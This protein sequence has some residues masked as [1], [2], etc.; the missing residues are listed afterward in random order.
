MRAIIVR[1]TCRKTV[2]KAFSLQTV[3]FILIRFLRVL[4][5]LLESGRQLT[6]DL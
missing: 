5:A 6:A 3:I 2:R 1:V 4:K